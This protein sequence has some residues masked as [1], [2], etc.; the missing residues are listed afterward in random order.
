MIELQTIGLVGLGMMGRGIASCLLSR[1]FRVR[2]F[3]ADGA[4]FAAAQREIEK[5]LQELVERAG[6]SP[7][8]LEQWRGRYLEADSPGSYGDC[9]FVIECVSENFE[10]KQ[11]VFAELEAVL[12]AD[13][14]IASNTSA[15]SITELQR[16]L[17]NPG[18]LIGMHWADP[19]HITRFLEVIRGEQ[20]SEATY[21]AAVKLARACGKDPSLV[22]HD[23]EGFIVNRLGY[24]VYREALNLLESGIADAQ[25]IDVA[26]RNALGL[27]AGIAGPFRAMDYYGLEP[28]ASAM[29][30]I[31]PT[32]S[33]ATEPPKQVEKMVEEGKKGMVGGQGFYSYTPD[34]ITRWK[35]IFR[36]HAWEMTGLQN[37]YFPFDESGSSPQP[38]PSRSPGAPGDRAGDTSRK[39][40]P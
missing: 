28:S 22:R 12:A 19:A 29:K 36:Q 18:R 26:F 5:N 32:L 6:F 27:W 21:I 34:E 1:G 35:D 20:T 15:L 10:V 8:I 39:H 33:N 40:Q 16:A 30:T 3:S 2:V 38:S 23:I 24:A 17:R 4:L 31:F 13:V 37:R 11:S 14:P 25:T 9:D 7:V